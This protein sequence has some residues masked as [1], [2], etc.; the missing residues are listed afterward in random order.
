MVSVCKLSNDITCSHYEVTCLMVNGKCLYILHTKRKKEYTQLYLFVF[1]RN[2]TE[3]LNSCD[4]LF[5]S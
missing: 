1:D 5:N 3:K 4:I 2:Q